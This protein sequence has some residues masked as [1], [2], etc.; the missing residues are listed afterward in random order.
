MGAILSF[1]AGYLATKFFDWITEKALSIPQFFD[2]KKNCV[3][4]IQNEAV[5]ELLKLSIENSMK[6]EKLRQLDFKEVEKSLKENM[7][8]IFE[9]ILLSNRSNIS[10][11]NFSDKIIYDVNKDS[12]VILYNS[13]FHQI[14]AYK[15]NY[16]T[17]QNLLILDKLDEI[18]NKVTGNFELTKDIHRLVGIMYQGT[19]YTGDLKTIED[20]IHLRQFNE[21]R[22]LLF[23][24][25]H[26]ILGKGDPE[27]T[28][29]Y[30]QLLT[31]SYFFDTMNQHESIKYLEKL[32]IHTTD[33][34]KRK[35]REILKYLLEHNFKSVQN[36]LDIIFAGKSN[37]EI[38]Q[39][40]FDI[41]VNS[42]I[43]QKKLDLAIDFVQT[44][45]EKFDNFPLWICRLYYYQYNTIEA[46]KVLD[47]NEDFFNKSDFEIQIMKI[48]I[49]SAH[50]LEQATSKKNIQNISNLN[51][52]IPKVK[53]AI[54]KCRD[55]IGI[56]SQ[57]H[58]ILGLIY[59]ILDEPEK[60]RKEYDK[61]LE[62]DQQNM[63]T[64]KN[65]PFVLINSKNRDDK[66]R[67]LKY[68]E[69][70][71]LE[72][73]EDQEIETLYFNSLVF[74][75]PKIAVEKLQ[76]Y[77]GQ[78]DDV[79][80]F[81][82]YAY[83]IL[84][85]FTK[86]ETLIADFLS[87]E[88]IS[89]SA[90]FFIALHYETIKKFDIALDFYFKA[91]DTAETNTELNRTVDKL[92][93]LTIFLKDKSN[94]NKGIKTIERLFSPDE[95]VL[96]FIDIFSYALLI[97]PDYE[98]CYR[99]CSIAIQHGVKSRNIYESVFS[100]YYNTHNFH[101]AFNIIEKYIEDFGQPPSYLLPFIA[102]SCIQIDRL[103]KAYEIISYLPQ[104]ESVSDYLL[105]VRFLNQIKKYDKALIIAHKA[106]L[107]FP[108]NQE[109]ME[110]FLKFVFNRSGNIQ[111]EEIAID[112][113]KC[114][115]DY[116]KSNFHNKELNDFYIDT[117][118]TPEEI[119]K[120]LSDIL[121]DNKKMI[122]HLEQ[123]NSKKLAMVFYKNI[124]NRN[125]LL[126]HYHIISQKKLKIWCFDGIF[127][128][129]TITKH[130]SIYIDIGSLL[131]LDTL[132][133]LNIL[134]E[135]FSNIFIPQSIFDE[136][137]NFEGKIPPS[138]A[139]DVLVKDT[140]GN[141]FIIKDDIPYNDIFEKSKRIIIFIKNNNA[142]K[143]VGRPLQIINY[144]P[145]ELFELIKSSKFDIDLNIIEYAFLSNTPI[146][147]EN[148]VYR[149]MFNALK[150][151]PRAFCVV[152]YLVYLLYQNKITFG[153]YCEMLLLMSKQNYV[154]LPLNSKVLYF[155]IQNNGYII[156]S[157]ITH[158]FDSFIS[159]DYNKEYVTVNILSTILIIWNTMIP[160]DIKNKWTDYL[161]NK[162]IVFCNLTLI[163]LNIICDAISTLIYN[164]KSQRDF[165]SFFEKYLK[166][167]D[168]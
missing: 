168:S 17:L 133:I 68:I 141:V 24:L 74:T 75:S 31:D 5:K 30:Y 163:D 55:E 114:L 10:F 158:I 11:S 25:E 21:A 2:I 104:P 49:L 152:D 159:D 19:V 39:S 137:R 6:N 33:N 153:K 70:Y 62:L 22:S 122:E 85:E 151:T 78:N 89:S 14:Q 149:R 40:Y 13:L 150:N 42:F 86:A 88:N 4:A 60:A 94:I 52:F 7:H 120:Q 79:K 166:N 142:V 98:K 83:D 145:Q 136:L 23:S 135:H 109:I 36:E 140:N 117:K 73:P 35:K 59:A 111:S 164:M 41:Q 125:I 155:L 8:I 129:S 18:D 112:L 72:Y 139:A 28:E 29:K 167:E 32:I 96:R 38:D 95:I 91:L 115:T 110:M 161:I 53:E 65:Y 97:L 119:Q 146:M 45:K 26:K 34:E 107:A 50:Y 64:L 58:S 1:L 43:F 9:W 132:G 56:K 44:N 156:D 81:L 66:E 102:T 127:N 37:I 16:P 118:A 15:N 63:N 105:Q 80:P 103:E 12:F 134:P 20:K 82:L 99:Y 69:Q 27:E 76:A 165:L 126:V 101:S 144:L 162:L 3:P 143:I 71:L 51:E 130:S 77:N 100:C 123:I 128:T 90:F 148:I 106:Y 48:N 93:R 57:M 92:L 138:N 121:P 108:K 157:S 131:L 124:L 87:K 61:S 160:N 47:E 84:C 113:H 116:I 154:S 67:A 46:K 54:E 147:L